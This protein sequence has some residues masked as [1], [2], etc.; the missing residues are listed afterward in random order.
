MVFVDQTDQQAQTQRVIAVRGTSGDNLPRAWRQCLPLWKYVTASSGEKA[1]R[2]LPRGSLSE[3]QFAVG[4]LQGART[5]ARGHLDFGLHARAAQAAREGF[6]QRG[7][8]IALGSVN[9]RVL[10][11]ALQGRIHPAVLTQ[12]ALEAVQHDQ[13]VRPAHGFSRSVACWYTWSYLAFHQRCLSISTRF[14][15]SQ[16]PFHRTTTRPP[17]TI[18]RDQRCC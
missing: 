12:Q 16:I 13:D 18:T 11:I 1:V 2:R 4:A 8:A 5:Q 14:S 7:G 15:R 6:G 10:V 17:Y 3:E 9:V